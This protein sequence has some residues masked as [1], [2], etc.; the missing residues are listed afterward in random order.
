MRE[1]P[2]RSRG[3]RFEAGWATEDVRTP[4]ALTGQTGCRW[5]SG[6][7]SGNPPR[8]HG[9]NCRSGNIPSSPEEPP[10][11]SRGKPSQPDNNY[12]TLNVNVSTQAISL[13]HTFTADIKAAEN[14]RRQGAEILA[15]GGH[16]IWWSFLSEQ[17]QQT[18]M[19]RHAQ[20]GHTWHQSA[21]SGPFSGLP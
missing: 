19:P 17:E 15:K 11:R 16:Q 18:A 10:P 14:I 4:P 20:T 9:A 5:R 13:L 21:L 2:P 6:R 1:P 7:C 12:H 3:K 8:A